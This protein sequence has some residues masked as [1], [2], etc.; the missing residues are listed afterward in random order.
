MLF[1]GLIHDNK[2]KKMVW[3]WNEFTKLVFI[4]PLREQSMPWNQNNKQC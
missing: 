1:I 4:L 2:K 3:W